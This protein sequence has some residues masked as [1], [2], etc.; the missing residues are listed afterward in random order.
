MYHPGDNLDNAQRST[1]KNNYITK[2]RKK[3]KVETNLGTPNTNNSERRIQEERD[4]WQQP[5]P[6]ARTHTGTAAAER[7]RGG[8]GSNR[9]TIA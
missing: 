1:K 6:A 3:V 8:A 9:T 2:R 4:S 7:Q 5:A